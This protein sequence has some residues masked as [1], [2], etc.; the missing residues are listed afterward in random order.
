MLLSN[1]VKFQAADSPFLAPMQGEIQLTGGT[2]GVKML[3]KL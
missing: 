2:F 1:A 3:D